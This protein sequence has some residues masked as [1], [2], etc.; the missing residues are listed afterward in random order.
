[1]NVDDDVKSLIASVDAGKFDEHLKG[2]EG[3]HFGIYAPVFVENGTVKMM[4]KGYSQTERNLQVSITPTL[5][6]GEEED[7]PALPVGWVG[8]VDHK[9]SACKHKGGCN[10]KHCTGHASH[11]RH[12]GGH[13]CG[14]GVNEFDAPELDYANAV[15][16]LSDHEDRLQKLAKN[17]FGLTLLHGHSE[18]SMFTVLPTDYVSVISNGV[19]SFRPVTEVES[20]QTFVPNV[21]RVVDGQFKIAGGYSEN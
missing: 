8:G 10:C 20:D 3:T 14:M 17:N 21:W 11:C 19:T 2:L 18:N 15:S 16:K 9:D 4:L 5:G 1:M 12:C 6:G 7:A 13:A